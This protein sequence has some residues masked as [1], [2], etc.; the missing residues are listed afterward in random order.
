VQGYSNL[1]GAVDSL[2]V[3]IAGSDTALVAAAAAGEG[4]D[5][6]PGTVHGIQTFS[7]TKKREKPGLVN[8]LD[9]VR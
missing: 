9:K 6:G 1:L 8:I 7:E 2:A 3:D 4:N 5:D